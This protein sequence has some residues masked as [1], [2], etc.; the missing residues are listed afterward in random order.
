MLQLRRDRVRQN[1]Q[2]MGITWCL[3][4]AYRLLIG[5][6]AGFAVHAMAHHSD[7]FGDSVDLFPSFLSHFLPIIA[8][9][10]VVMSA[11]AFL[12]GWGLLT[13]KP[14]GRTLAIIMAILTL[15]KIP[16]GTALGIYTL[17]VLAPRVS[18]M[19]YESLSQGMPSRL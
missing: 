4:G 8:V 5:A 18:G 3:W 16:L 17:W 10:A 1:L 19:E 12:T 13:A 7:W 9:S 6:A 14:W 15:I 2:P 11:L